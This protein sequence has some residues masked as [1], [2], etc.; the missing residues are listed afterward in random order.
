MVDGDENIEFID[1]N[2]SA[3]I[4]QMRANGQKSNPANHL[5]APD[6][7]AFSCRAC[8]KRLGRLSIKFILAIRRQA[9]V[10]I[11]ARMLHPT[12]EL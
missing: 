5:P 2:Y 3:A 11:E 7:G 6:G 12:Q 8:R 1:E 10:R 4:R 9:D